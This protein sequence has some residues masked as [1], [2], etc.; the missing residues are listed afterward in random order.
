MSS[1]IR[2]GVCD[3]GSIQSMKRLFPTSLALLLVIGSLGHVFA[4]VFCPRMQGHDCCPTKIAS[5][6]HGTHSH[7]H[8]QGMAM[9]TVADESMQMNESDMSGTMEHPAAPHRAGD[10]QVNRL[11]SSDVLVSANRVEVPL[12]ACTH[13]MSHSGMQNA[14]FSSVKAPDQSNKD[15][16]S[17]RLP[18]SRFLVGP[19]ITLAQIGLP[20][21]HA[22]PG[23][24]AALHILINVFLI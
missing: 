16:G 4:A 8:M 12:D 9:G 17:H 15:L 6:K 10:V 11:F 7:K 22:P 20:R 3:N 1:Q 14:P 18:A 5:S 21:E 2:L 19:A 23:S 13:C 24:S